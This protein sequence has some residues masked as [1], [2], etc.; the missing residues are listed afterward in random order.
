MRINLTLASVLGVAAICL[1][2][3]EPPPRLEL[4]ENI[5]PFNLSAITGLEQ[6]QVF[7]EV[8]RVNGLPREVREALQGGIADPWQD[9]NAGDNI[10]R[11]LPMRSLIVAA[12]SEKYCILSYWKGGGYP[13]PRFQTVIFELSE[14]KARPIWLSRAQGGFSFRDLK[15]M[16]ESGRMRND[17]KQSGRELADCAIT[18]SC[19]W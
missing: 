1:S 3:T 19:G 14:P 5:A 7:R 9:Y 12:V 13:G 15:E 17:L 8:T 18:N 2:C 4:K 6:A 11:Q 10:I 16:V